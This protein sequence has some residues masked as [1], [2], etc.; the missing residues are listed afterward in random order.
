MRNCF[1]F[2]QPENW[3]WHSDASLIGLTELTFFQKRTNKTHDIH[4]VMSRQR[5]CSQI[6]AS[7][8]RAVAMCQLLLV[9][10]LRF[11]S[12]ST[13]ASE[14]ARV[15]HVWQVFRVVTGKTFAEV[16]VCLE[17]LL[18]SPQSFHPALWMPGMCPYGFLFS[19]PTRV[20]WVDLQNYTL[21]N[22]INHMLETQA[23]KVVAAPISKSCC[24]V[25]GWLAC[26]NWAWQR[27]DKLLGDFL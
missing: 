6:P 5:W 7:S 17:G 26:L 8:A 10:A 2:C 24:L 21:A 14:S 20:R 3:F 12:Q 27:R 22:Q 4:P 15:S 19:M 25:T 9:S 23:L 11:P 18:L 13:Y 1:I 16:H